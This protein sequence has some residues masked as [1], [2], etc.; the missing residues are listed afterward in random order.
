MGTIEVLRSTPGISVSIAHR[1]ATLLRAIL[2]GP[3]A[4][5]ATGSAAAGVA[6]PVI[7]IV[8]PKFVK[9][10]ARE[11]TSL[12]SIAPAPESRVIIADTGSGVRAA[13]PATL[14]KPRILYDAGGR[15]VCEV[16]AGDRVALPLM[17]RARKQTAL[18]LRMQ[19]PAGARPGQRFTVSIV[20]RDDAG[21]A[22]GGFT[23]IVN[24]VGKGNQK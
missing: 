10:S 15:A 23:V 13:T 7:E 1:D 9:L 4:R 19:P 22:S 17:L 11:G 18:T 12:I 5:S 24:V 16:P 6:G 2:Y 8:S 14:S 20:Q 3:V 21:R